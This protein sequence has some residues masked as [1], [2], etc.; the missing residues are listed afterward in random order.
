MR[1]YNEVGA[2]QLREVAGVSTM[3]LLIGCR[4]PVRLRVRGLDG[5]AAAAPPDR[6]GRARR[7]RPRTVPPAREWLEARFISALATSI[8]P[9]ASGG[10]SAQWH[11]EVLWA[12]DRQTRCLLALVC[13]H[14]EPG[15]FELF[16]ARR[17]ATALFEFRKGHW[18]AEG[19]RLDEMRPDEAVGRNQRSRRSPSR[20]PIRAGSA[21]PDDRLA[22]RGSAALWFTTSFPDLGVRD[23]PQ[24]DVLFERE[25]VGPADFQQRALAALDLD[26]GRGQPWRD[27]VGDQA[28]AVLVGVDQVAG[29]DL[30]PA[31]HDRRAEID[32]PDVGVADAGVQAEE[33]E[34]ER[35]DLVQVARAAAGDVADAAE[36]LV[37]R[38]G[39]L[40]ELGTQ[41]G[42]VVEVPADR[43]LRAGQRRDVAQSSRRADRPVSPSARAGTARVC[44]VTA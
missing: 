43:D 10:R 4:H 27:L 15:P 7:P 25:V 20:R 40:A 41:A 28:N 11:D 17:H 19:K 23:G 18:C 32:Q 9:K 33:L 44:D 34:S 38:R 3:G 5:P 39:D 1:F 21:E 8:P 37:D 31:D 22:I 16:Q 29:V 30:D 42:R 14:F 13:V 26:A 24:L 6:R 35:L 2:C 36:L 12:R